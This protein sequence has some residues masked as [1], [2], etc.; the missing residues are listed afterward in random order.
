MPAKS[1][2]GGRT[3]TDRMGGGGGGSTTPHCHSIAIAANASSSISPGGDESQLLPSQLPAITS[4]EVILPQ[5]RRCCEF[6]KPVA[7]ESDSSC[8]HGWMRPSEKG[9]RE[10][11]PAE[12]GIAVVSAVVV[13]WLCMAAQRGVKET[14]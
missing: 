5:R 12:G 10:R 3:R 14:K 7:V 9:G 13:G 8:S 1:K 2:R 11:A 4:F 6:K